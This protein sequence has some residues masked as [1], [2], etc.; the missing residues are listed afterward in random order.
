MNPRSAPVLVSMT[1]YFGSSGG[2]GFLRLIR[3]VGGILLLCLSLAS[4]GEGRLPNSYRDALRSFFTRNPPQMNVGVAHIHKYQLSPRD[5][6]FTVSVVVPAL[7]PTEP[8]DLADLARQD[9][10]RPWPERF[11][12]TDGDPA[13]QM[14]LVDQRPGSVLA[15]QLDAIVV[16]MEQ[17]GVNLQQT[18]AVL[19]EIRDHTKD[20]Y[21][22]F[23]S[24]FLRG[25]REGVLRLEEQVLSPAAQRVFQNFIGKE[26]SGNIWPTDDMRPSLPFEHYLAEPSNTM[27]FHNAMLASLV[28]QR[29]GVAH[30]LRTGFASFNSP[31]YLNTGHTVIELVDGR[32]LDPTWGILKPIKRH[33]EHPEWISGGAWWWTPHAHYPY[34]VLD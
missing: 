10:N 21:S 3:K 26:I 7:H 2:R 15:K 4:R 33:S 9:P 31:S 28:L 19:G 30:R 32:F 34:L 12:I 24:N 6:P 27:C 11:V 25:T 16:D 20:Y 13:A 22:R 14:I 17:R 1:C 8:S 5:Q 29:V 18:E 23:E